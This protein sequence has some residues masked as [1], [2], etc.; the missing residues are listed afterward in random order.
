MNQRFTLLKMMVIP[1]FLMVLLMVA[2]C[3]KDNTPSDTGSDLEFV[4]LTTERDTIV[5]QELT[6]ITANVKGDGLSYSWKCDNELA[7][8]DG[9][10]AEIY[11]TIC[12]AGKFKITCD[13]KDSNN[14]TASKEVYVTTIE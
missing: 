2:A 4:S 3:K 7:V 9:S 13:V 8:L 1:T 12:H 10:G 6:K 11:F 5:V 14:N